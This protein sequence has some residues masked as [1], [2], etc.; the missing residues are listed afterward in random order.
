[1]KTLYGV[2]DSNTIYSLTFHIPTIDEFDVLE[3]TK[4]VYWVKNGINWKRKVLKSEMTN[5]AYTFYETYEEARSALLKA[6]RYYLENAVKEIKR[7]QDDIA[8]I[9]AVLKEQFDIEV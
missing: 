5:G 3:E 4:G 9:V 6:L 2:C 7:H 8:K 1:M